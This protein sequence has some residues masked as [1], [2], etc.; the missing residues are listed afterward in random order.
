MNTDIKKNKP[1]KTA[2]FFPADKR[3][4]L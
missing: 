3:L 1:V 2:A 4:S